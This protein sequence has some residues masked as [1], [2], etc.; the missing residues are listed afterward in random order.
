MMQPGLREYDATLEHCE[1]AHDTICYTAVENTREP[2]PCFIRWPIDRST[3]SS[4]TSS[5]L[6]AQIR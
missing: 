6:Q 3:S 2:E 4:I 5:I 1:Y